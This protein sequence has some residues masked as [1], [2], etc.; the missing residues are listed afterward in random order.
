MR[1][2]LA[3]AIPVEDA[4]RPAVAWAFAYFFCVLSAYFVIR[5]LREEMGIAGGVENLQWLFTATFVGML[6]AVPLYSALVARWP[7]RVFVPVV[8]H[9]FVVNLIVFRVLLGALEGEAAVHVA[10]AFFVW[11]SVFNLFAVSVFWSLM[12]D[13]FTNRQAKRLFGLIAAGGSVGALTGSL[14]TAGLVEH[15]GTLN[16]LWI[17]VVLLE[18]AVLCVV[19]LRRTVEGDELERR[20]D[21]PAHPEPAAEGVIGGGVLSGL[22]LIAASPYL[23]GICGYMFLSTLCATFVYFQQAELM[24]REMP[25]P[26]ART[27]LFAQINFAVQALTLVLQALVTARLIAWLG[28]AGTL[29]FLPALYAGGFAA[30]GLHTLLGVVVAFE[31]LRRAVGY[32]VATPSKEVLFTVVG[33]E[34]KYKSKSFIDTVVFRGGDAASAWIFRGLTGAGL[35]LSAVAWAAVPLSLVWLVL[36]RGL[37]RAQRVRGEAPASAVERPA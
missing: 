5:P 7:R 11:T 19:R 4:E 21:G 6:V 10:R 37:G 16:L 26:E 33:R 32:G 3:R 35:G 14:V 30:L 27:R 36:A 28:L 1:S 25:D 9:F 34:E 24:Q 13:L 22:R 12:A 31:V 29:C 20:P 8:Y 17:P 2:L 18:L 23:L 15:L